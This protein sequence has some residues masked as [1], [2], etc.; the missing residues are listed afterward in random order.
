M[1]I[2]LRRKAE[3][4]KKGGANSSPIK[5]LAPSEAPWQGNFVCVVCI[6]WIVQHV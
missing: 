4:L 6:L 1:K 5:E 2:L 3:V